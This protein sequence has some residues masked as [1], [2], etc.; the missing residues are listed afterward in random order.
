MSSQNGNCDTFFYL[1]NSFSIVYIKKNVVIFPDKQFF[2]YK[3]FKSFLG[4]HIGKNGTLLASLCC[5]AVCLSR[6][7]ISGT[8][9]VKVSTY[10]TYFIPKI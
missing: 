1:T 3:I 8:A 2:L 6:P 10:V 7:I 9:E 5:P 4:F